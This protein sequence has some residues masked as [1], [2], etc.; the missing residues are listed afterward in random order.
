MTVQYHPGERMAQQLAGLRAEAEMSRLAIGTSI[1][2]VAAQFVAQQPLLVLGA[3]DPDERMWASLLVGDPG[4]AAAPDERTLDVAAVPAPGDP[5]RAALTEPVPVGVIL[6]DPSTRRRMRVN[7]DAEP[8]PEGLRI[9]ANQVYAN[10]PKYIQQRRVDGAGSRAVTTARVSDALSNDQR[11]LIATADTFFV[12]TRSAAGAA[13]ASHRGGSP[14]FVQVLGDR[15]LRWPDYVGNAMMMTLGNLQQDPAA[16]LLFVDW[17]AGTTVQV[18][19]RAEVEWDAD[20]DLP[21]ARRQVRFDVERVVQL[22]HA[23]PLRWTAPVPSRFN[24]PLSEGSS[25]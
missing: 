13:D 17:A 24:P 10:C 4:F 15:S 22:D 16:G 20:P 25:S 5:L 9:T 8:T 12:A 2:A 1:P 23:S 19:G 21:G 11:R 18:S 7:G 3:A 6:I 14:G